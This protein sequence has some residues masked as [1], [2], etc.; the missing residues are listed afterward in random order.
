M[1][2]DIT[3]PFITF[4]AVCMGFTSHN[5]YFQKKTKTNKQTNKQ[6]SIP[7]IRTTVGIIVDKKRTETSGSTARY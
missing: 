7:K 1:I 3:E 5:N 4:D 6:T 2:I